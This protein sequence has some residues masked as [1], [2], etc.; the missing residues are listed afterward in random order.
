MKQCQSKSSSMNQS[1]GDT[2][3][4]DGETKNKSTDMFIRG[5]GRHGAVQRHKLV[6]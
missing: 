3:L 4:R 2:E 6:K 5:I 1:Y